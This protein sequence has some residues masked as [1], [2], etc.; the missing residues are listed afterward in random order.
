[1]ALTPQQ[2]SAI[3]QIIAARGQPT[4][5][6]AGYAGTGKSFVLA[7]G[8]EDADCVVLA[9][10]NKA[11]QR[12]RQLGIDAQTVHSFCYTVEEVPVLDVDGNPVLDA[13]GREET[14]LVFH[15]RLDGDDP[16]RYASPPYI[17]VDEASMVG[18]K[19]FNDIMRFHD[20]F[21]S[22]IVLFG[23]PFQLKPVNDEDIFG[24]A[25]PDVFFKEIHRVAAENPVLE[26]SQFIREE[27][28]PYRYGKLLD[29]F[30]CFRWQDPRAAKVIFDPESQVICWRN[31][32]RKMINKGFREMLGFTSPFP[33]E[34]DRIVFLAN[35]LKRGLFNG[36]FVT[37]T[38][39]K[40]L[41]ENSIIVDCITE[42]G[43]ELKAVKL[44]KE[45]FL[46]YDPTGIKPEKP[47]QG[48]KADYSY[49]ITAHKSQGSE[50]PSIVVIDEYTMIKKFP[51][52]DRRRWF[53]TAVTR[54][55]GSLAIVRK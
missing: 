10:T 4:F 25:N 21:G 55:R 3:D 32:T 8:A 48:I 26:F 35:D 46:S 1:M 9:P 44:A 18:S 47:W 22:T 7:A 19:M 2:Q 5:R 6:V 27:P 52:E 49:A 51:L 15:H 17:F 50:W 11:A 20:E 33:M 14:E 16:D 13:F 29:A 38:A 34:G 23:D 31:T 42:D 43:I 40:N 45:E 39:V 12:L 28:N 37:V 30:T 24:Q 53:Y 41:M 36:L 54:T